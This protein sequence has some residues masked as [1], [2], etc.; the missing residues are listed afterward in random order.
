MSDIWTM[1]M[2]LLIDMLVDTLISRRGRE[3]EEALAMF[4]RAVCECRNKADF[5]SCVVDK[6]QKQSMRRL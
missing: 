3:S 6:L 2:K 5:C 1:I 4:A